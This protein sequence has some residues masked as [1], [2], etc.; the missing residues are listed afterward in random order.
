[1]GDLLA[2]AIVLRPL[3]EPAREDRL[4]RKVELLVRVGRKVA[5]GVLADDLLVLT[6]EGLQVRHVE[7][8]VLRAVTVGL[9]AGLERLVEAARGNVHHDPPEHRDEPAVRVPAEA[10]VAGQRDEA[11]ERLL[12]EAEV[13][14]GVHHPGH[15]ELG[16]GAD[17]H[18][19]RVLRVAEALAGALLDLPHR[20]EDVVP[21]PVGQLLAGG[22]VVVARFGRDREA[23]RGRQAGLR[24]LGEPGALAPEQV[25]HRAVALGRAAAPRVDVALAGLVGAVGRG[26]RR[27]HSASSLGAARPVGG[28]GFSFGRGHGRL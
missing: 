4:D 20:L 19:E 27:C 24:H 17:A 1:M 25:L 7:V 14:D 16:A 2:V 28:A 10:L 13:E 8:G 23:G 26:G 3:A 15:R 18:E 22:E 12:V 9:L 6:D 5:P 21:E 11:L